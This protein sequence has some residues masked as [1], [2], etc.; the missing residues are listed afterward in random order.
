MS[1]AQPS[2]NQ[3]GSLRR[4]WKIIRPRRGR[5]ALSVLLA[6]LSLACAIGLIATSAWLISR[7][8]QQPPI[9]ALGVAVTAVRALGL[10]RGVFRY[11][12]RLVSHGAA[13]RG[14][15]ALRVQ[16]VDRIA[17]V[18]PGGTSRLRHGDALRR[19]VD[20]VDTSSEFG[21]R[22]I[23]PGATAVFVGAGVVVLVSW[24]LPLAGLAMLIG[25]LIGGVLAPLV[26]GVVSRR[27]ATREVHLKGE[28]SAELTALFAASEEFVA[29]R[30][31]HVGV[32]E[33]R[34]LDSEIRQ[35]ERTTAKGMGLAAGIGAAAQGFALLA[36]IL[37]AVPA[38]VAGEL[39][40]VNLAVVVLIPLVAF[41]LVTTMPAAAIWLVKSRTSAGRI[42]EILD[43]PNAVSDP[44]TPRDL[45][46]DA[47]AYPWLSVRSASITWPG[48]AHPAISGINLELAPGKRIAII[49][50]S[51]AGKSSLAAGLVKL[52]PMAGE[53]SLCGIKYDEL[54]GDRVRE[55]IGYS[56]QHAHIFDNTIAEN[57][58]LARRDAS[59]E[60]IEQALDRV[61]LGAWVA[62]LPAGIN[63][64]VGQHGAQ[65]S[66]G[67]RQR[68][69]LARMIL[70]DPPIAIF[71]EPTEH[72]D[73]VTAAELATDIL[74]VM[75]DRSVIYITHLSHGL[76]LVDEVI[77]LG[78]EGDATYASERT[79]VGS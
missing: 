41:E 58:R 13:L 35:A 8:W 16:L 11:S 78:R 63:T 19:F 59:D 47:A 9:L 39:N 52:A 48:E 56:A 18:A 77:E 26:T 36:V 42:V 12:E 17:V 20:D 21:L 51:G 54:T 22:T 28:L 79:S 29:A 30:A 27:A 31:T 65:L 69:A 5:G 53:I 4:V 6:S 64:R 34:S 61:K 2:A 44:V 32:S 62:S 71:D 3:P 33:V 75:S 15:T 45:P 49:G 68:L 67:Q 24:L 57:V 40:G 72:L 23:L 46:E 25:L 37:V 10:G 70:A 43:A 1:P 73:A 76:D 50:P 38:V 7:A 74:T 66:G 55:V 14:L 60:Q